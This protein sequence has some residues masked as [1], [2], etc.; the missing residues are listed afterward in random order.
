MSRAGAAP[1]SVDDATRSVLESLAR[2][3]TAAHREVARARALLLAADA[4]AV[5]GHGDL[6]G[7]H[8]GQYRLRAGA[9]TRVGPVLPGPVVFVI[10][11]V[12]GDLAVERCLQD[13]L[14]QLL[15]QPA[16][17]G[18]LQTLRPGLLAELAD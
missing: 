7:A 14:G 9:V 6:D 2:S 11:Q 10:A 1:L 15:Q 18:E 3:G 8:L 13:P 12:V 4:V 5:A 17:T 16:L